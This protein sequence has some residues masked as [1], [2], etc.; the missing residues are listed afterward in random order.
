[1]PNCGK[2]MALN[3]WIWTMALNVKLWRDDYGSE[4][5]TGMTALN[6]KLWTTNLNAKLRR[7]GGFELLTMDAVLNANY[8]EMVALNTWL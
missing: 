5:Q 1:M 3:A 6:A 8:G 7:D 2:M 4:C